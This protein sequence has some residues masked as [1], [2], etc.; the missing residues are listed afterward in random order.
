MHAAVQKDLKDYEEGFIDEVGNLPGEA[1]IVVDKS[2]T[3][4]VSPSHS[5]PHAL[6]PKL[7]EELAKLVQLGVLTPVTKPTDLVSQL[8]IITKHN[9]DIRACLDLYPLNHALKRKHFHIPCL[10]DLLP[11]LSKVKV[12]STLDLSHSYILV[13]MSRFTRKDAY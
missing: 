11:S 5:V 12:L 1:H 10:D 4:S 3:P 9:S 8:V 2:V 6:K 13:Y 7:K